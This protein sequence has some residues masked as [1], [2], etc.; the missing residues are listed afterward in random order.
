MELIKRKLRVC[1]I[2]QVP[3]KPFIVEVRD[4][5][6]AYLIDNALAQQHLFLFENNV[7]P[8]YSNVIFV[9]YLDEDGEWCTYYNEYEFMEWDEFVEEYKEQLK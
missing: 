9:E 4:E 3:M 6:E 7:I 8:D 1:H 2:P 5:R